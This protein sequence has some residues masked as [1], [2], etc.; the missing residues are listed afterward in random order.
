[1]DSGASTEKHGASTRIH[2]IAYANNG[3][4]I[5]IEYQRL[6][7]KSELA[8]QWC[9]CL[10]RVPSRP[11]AMIRI[12]A[13]WLATEPMDLRVGTAMTLARVIAVF[14]AAEAALRLSICQSPRDSNE[15]PG[16]RW[17]WLMAGRTSLE[18][19]QVSLAKPSTRQRNAVG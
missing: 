4:P 19:R 6:H 18:P 10:R 7:H 1:M 17:D 5:F 12:D 14:G 9:C 13:I 11:V 8:N 15:S 3:A 16:T 2:S